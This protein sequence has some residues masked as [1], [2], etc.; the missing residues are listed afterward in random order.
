MTSGQEPSPVAPGDG[1]RDTRNVPLV[2][3]QLACLCIQTGRKAGA[4]HPEA[5]AFQAAANEHASRSIGGQAG[6]GQFGLPPPVQQFG[7]PQFAASPYGGPPASAQFAAPPQQFAPP[8]QQFAPPPQQFAPLPQQ[9]AAP[10]QQFVPPPPQQ[11]A[12]A[13]FAS[14][15]PSSA[16]YPA[17]PAG[18]M[19]NAAAS[20]FTDALGRSAHRSASQHANQRK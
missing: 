3:N 7:P 4:A 18:F 5:T 9:F 19:G 12:A 8:P 2:A 20:Q 16:H 11:F 6:F 10:P 17:L 15:S 14:M 1:M 13:P